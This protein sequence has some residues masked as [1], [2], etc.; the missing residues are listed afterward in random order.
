MSSTSSTDQVFA[1]PELITA[2][3]L[4]L[5]IQDI[6]THAQ[7]VNRSWKLAVDS[8]PVQQAVFLTPQQSDH[9][10]KPKFNPLLKEKFPSWFNC[11]ERNNT[12]RDKR[13][14]QFERLEWGSSPEKCA[15]YARKEASW[16]QMLP[17]QPPAT[18]FEVRKAEHYQGRSYLKVGQ[19][20][21]SEGVRMGT[22]YDWAQ[23]T[24]RMPISEFQMKWHMV[25]P[26]EDVELDF[27][28]PPDETET[29]D[30]IEK[31]MMGQGPPKV[32]M[33]TSYTMQCDFGM[34]PDVQPKFISEGYEDLSIT[35]GGEKNLR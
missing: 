16:R 11:A 34:E 26:T 17:V 23:K 33:N 15:A 7:L 1:V 27:S 20:A 24:F 5:P 18:I 2:I 30:E 12:D 10:M 9:G 8:L 19:V 28:M 6:L 3:I 22:L 21:F 13:G 29:P 25:S 31:R 32:T 14:W 4:Q 35:W